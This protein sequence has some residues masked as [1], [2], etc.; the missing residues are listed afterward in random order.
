MNNALAFVVRLA[1]GL[2]PAR[3]G[4]KIERAAKPVARLL[5]MGCLDEAG[6]LRAE[7]GCAKRRD[8]LNKLTQPK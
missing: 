2:A 3:L 8:A 6:K 1:G 4:D 5:R 7:S